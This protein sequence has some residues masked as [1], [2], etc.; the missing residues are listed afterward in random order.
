MREASVAFVT[1]GIASG[2][3]VEPFHASAVVAFE[4]GQLLLPTAMQKTELTHETPVS[5][6]VVFAVAVVGMVVQL[7]ALTCAG[8]VRACG[9]A[10]PTG[11]PSVSTSGSAD[12]AT[13]N[14]AVT[15]RTADRMT[16]SS[17]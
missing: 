8:A 6:F 7:E 15:T 16:T 1:V 17:T 5:A 12:S 14:P 10:A 11:L 2:D 13:A 3:Q 9:L 4:P